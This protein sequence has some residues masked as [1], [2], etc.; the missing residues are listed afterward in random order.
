MNKLSRRSF[1]KGAGAG[2]LALSFAGHGLNVL[3]EEQSV[4]TYADTIAWD[5]AYDVVVVGFGI[6][7]GTAAYFAAKQGASVLLI[8]KAPEGNEGGNSRYAG[9]CIVHGSNYQDLEAYYR[10]IFANYSIPEESF[11]AYVDG[12]YNVLDMLKSD[13]G[14]EG[15]YSMK[16]MGAA[17]FY[18]PEYPEFPGSGTIDM[19]LVSPTV[20]DGS[21]WKGIK[22]RVAES[23]AIDVWYGCP[24]KHLIQDP[25]SKAI[26]GV[27]ILRNGQ[28]VKI[29]AHNGVVLSTGG[30][31]N[32][33]QMLQD[34]LN[35]TRW[36]LGGTT[37][38]T[39]DG[40]HMAQ[41]IGAD[42]WHMNTWEGRGQLF[43]GMSFPVPN[44]ERGVQVGSDS[45]NM[46]SIILVNGSGTRYLP[47]DEKARHGHI[48]ADGVWRN[49]DYPAVSYAVFDQKKYDY[50]MREQLLSDNF[51]SQII[52]GEGWDDLAA[53]TGMNAQEL[54]NQVE[55]FNHFAQ[56]G[57]DYQFGRSGQTMEAFSAEGPYYALEMVIG[58]LNTQGG[59]RRNPEAEVLFPDGTKIPHLYSAGELG[60][61]IC[62]QY[63]GGGNI[64]ECLM[65][66][67][68]AGLNAA[69]P[70]EPLPE[71][72]STPAQSPLTYT[73]DSDYDRGAQK[74]WQRMTL[75]DNEFIGVG[76]G[77]GGDVVV[78]V[79]FSEVLRDS[80]ASYFGSIVN[81]EVLSHH[82][83][84][85]IGTPALEQMPARFIAANSADVDTVA[86]AT[87]TSN[88]MI[89]AIR[90]AIAQYN[91][92]KR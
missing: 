32:N 92:Q 31:E 47:E 58:M 42:L 55:R 28:P 79:T 87:M 85:G 62:V 75:A 5:G 20:G 12:A 52:Q 73:I 51:K 77:M 68:K 49:P 38:N 61:T 36:S 30:F 67:R 25:M 89:E 84:E 2:A 27:E 56:T 65:Y 81:V 69:A 14:F 46:G 76:Q 83:T 44:G 17:D 71:L 64:M 88:A 57:T 78:L 53:K 91:A 18:T 66:G 48:Y 82:E 16:E 29:R 10:K 9:Q 90:D 74:D 80:S 8:D 43:G 72:A 39:G 7:G 1:L 40:V 37:Y 35:I 3:A 4:V 22:A 86:G 45:F 60:G 24:G 59:P 70:K 13:M 33:A 23:D 15:A 50:I 63:Q 26:V 54:Q 19:Y 34:Y 21:L 6:A 41:E 11:R